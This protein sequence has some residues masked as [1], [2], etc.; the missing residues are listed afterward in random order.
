MASIPTTKDQRLTRRAVRTRITLLVEFP[1]RRSQFLGNLW[2]A[3]CQRGERL[4]LERELDSESTSAMVASLLAHVAMVAILMVLPTVHLDAP[5]VV[6]KKPADYRLIYLRAESLTQMEDG[7]GASEDQEDGLKGRDAFHPEQ[8][9]RVARASTLQPVVADTPR[10]ILPEVQENTVNLVALPA[11]SLAPTLA[12][13]REVARGSRIVRDDRTDAEFA[14]ADQS[15]LQLRSEAG[16]LASVARADAPSPI[17][18]RPSR[19]TIPLETD[20]T[21]ARMPLVPVANLPPPVSNADGETAAPNAAGGII[22]SIQPRNAVGLPADGKPGSLALSPH[23]GV[24]PGLGGDREGVGAPGAADSG[25]GTSPIVGL[26]KSVSPGTDSGTGSGLDHSTSIP[27]VV[28]RGG[29]VSLASFGPKRAPGQKQPLT[30][31]A[32]KASPITV[33]A[34]SRSGGGLNAYGVFKNRMVYTIYFRTASTRVVLQFAAQDSTVVYD[35]ALTPP[36][37]ISTDVPAG[38]EEIAG[39]FSAVL[40][41]TGHLQ[42]IIPVDSEARNQPLRDALST[43]RFH[44]ALSANQAVAVDVLIGVGKD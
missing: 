32:R 23:G 34:T 31:V 17:I 40:D 44:P 10:L 39:V 25:S 20:N 38:G 42:N 41:A 27:G 29:V 2:V 3:F 24:Q 7:A 35:A 21:A 26:R 16:A 36:D 1:S 28:V 18:L 19:P 22:V 4:P 6:E 14:P 30:A 9:I 11:A 5:T 43:W 12:V 15:R 8:T 37:P 13:P 33:I